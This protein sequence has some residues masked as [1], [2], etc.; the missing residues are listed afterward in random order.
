[1]QSI[2]ASPLHLLT[3]RLE[4]VTSQSWRSPKEWAHPKKY[5][6]L[7]R[8]CRYMTV[9]CAEFNNNKV[10]VSSVTNYASIYITSREHHFAEGWFGIIGRV[11][12]Q[13][14]YSVRLSN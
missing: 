14:K 7:R 6:R 9:L 12:C 3:A 11:D 10:E 5:F 1:M 2:Y 8:I 4:A 13:P